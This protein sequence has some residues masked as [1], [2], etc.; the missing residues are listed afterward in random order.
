MR[1]YTSHK[2][3]PRQ[4]AFLSWDAACK[5]C[6]P[7]PS[8]SRIHLEN[9]FVKYQNVASA[10]IDSP[11]REHTTTSLDFK[12]YKN[13]CSYLTIETEN[14][15]DSKIIRNVL[16]PIDIAV[17]NCATTSLESELYK[18][19]IVDT[20]VCGAR[21]SGCTVRA[22]QRW[23]SSYCRSMRKWTSSGTSLERL[24]L[25]VWTVSSAETQRK[26]FPPTITL[27]K[28]RA[29]KSFWYPCTL[30]PYLCFLLYTTTSWWNAVF[31]W[32]FAGRYILWH[33]FFR[34][35]R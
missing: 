9:H 33:S 28:I 26:M 13:A 8:Y 12:S 17:A 4:T 35:S 5:N 15:T 27:L 14:W 21:S 31:T 2:S 34:Q 20:T 19:R 32:R 7:A 1:S 30:R 16:L 18:K 11:V 6:A 25:A 29:T 24:Q 10:K 3:W 22:E 23:I